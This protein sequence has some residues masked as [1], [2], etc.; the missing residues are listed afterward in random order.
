MT[1]QRMVIGGVIRGGVIVPER[2]LT[3]PEGT[4]VE[5]TF[6][7]AELPE[8]LRA[9]FASWERASEDAWVMIAKWE[10]EEQKAYSA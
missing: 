1:A 9:E 8:E 2:E 4:H 6:L 3:L 7:P 10:C 5:I